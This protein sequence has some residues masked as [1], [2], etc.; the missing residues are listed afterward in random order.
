MGSSRHPLAAERINKQQRVSKRSRNAAV[1]GTELAGETEGLAFINWTP[2]RDI[3]GEGTSAEEMP[4]A[5]VSVGMLVGG[6][7]FD[8]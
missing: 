4:P 6:T 2:A 8:S 1:D 7:V 5:D 3:W